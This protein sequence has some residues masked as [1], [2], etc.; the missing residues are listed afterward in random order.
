MAD[1]RPFRGLRF[2]PQA[3]A[4]LAALLAPPF[5]VISPQEQDLLHLQSP[6]NVVRLELG[7][8]S[9]EDTVEN[10]RYSRARALLAAWV[11]KGILIRE[12]KPALYLCLHTFRQGGAAR[13]RWELLAQVRLAEWEERV[14]LPH[15]FTLPGPKV[16]RLDLLR[17]TQTNIS[18]IYAVYRDPDGA[19]A[20]VL[21]EQ[22]GV[23]PV[24]LMEV[25]HWRDASFAVW[26]IDDA[27][28]IAHIRA[29]LASARLY[30]VDGHHRYETALAYRR[31]QRAVR[32]DSTGEEGFNNVFMSL[33]S[34][35]DP[36]LAVLPIHRMVR[37][38]SQAQFDGLRA[39][40]AREWELERLSLPL[41]GGEIDTRPLLE[42]LAK[43]GAAAP[44]FALYGLEP[45]AML[46]LRPRSVQQLQARLPRDWPDALRTL[47]LSLL[48]DV[49]L[50]GY[51]A[52]A[53]EAAHVEAALGFTHDAGEAL[54][55]VRTG[56]YQLAILVNPTRVDQLV[57]VAEAGDKMPQKSTFFYP[58]LPAGLVMRP[59]EET[60]SW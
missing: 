32:P 25:A 15:E 10:S 44:I 20:T 11:R 9:P 46:L 39:G 52:I 53:R 36:G 48:H 24:P 13:A 6:Y 45:G 4:D 41:S 29:H 17:A 38:L 40:L 23:S 50:H 34:L 27:D 33:T 22:A 14:V 30:I 37:G 2:G 49:I 60:S 35:A 21:E 54:T 16:D 57:E 42:Q 55:Q 12:D 58:K 56:A 26:A 59:L 18:H 43:A 31:E 47:D 1:V 19:L 3:G 28:V 8:T 7:K 5:D 51:L